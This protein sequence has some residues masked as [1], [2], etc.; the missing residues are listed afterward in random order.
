MATICISDGKSKKSSIITVGL[1]I[2]CFVCNDISGNIIGLQH[3]FYIGTVVISGDIT[4]GSVEA[5][6]KV[7]REESRN[8]HKFNVHYFH[9]FYFI[10][11]F[12]ESL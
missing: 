4:G 11:K 7:L 6:V 3:T 12:N 2:K 8:R 10:Y 9:L 5:V 1:L